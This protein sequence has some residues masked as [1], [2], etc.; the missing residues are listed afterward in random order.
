MIDGLEKSHIRTV[1]RIQNLRLHTL[2]GV[3]EKERRAKREVVFNVELEVSKDCSGVSDFL[4][5]AVD[6]AAVRDKLVAVAERSEARLLEHLAHNAL[7][8]LLDDQR[9]TSVVLTVEKPAALRMAEGVS[10]IKSWRR[11]DS[12]H[13][14]VL[15]GSNT[16]KKT[17]VCEV[18]Q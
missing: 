8:A 13:R 3:Y 11:S 9:I 10:V 12:P 1:V 7:D 18:S 16:E 17:E 14:S 4:D 6:Y 5:S 2:L 15:N